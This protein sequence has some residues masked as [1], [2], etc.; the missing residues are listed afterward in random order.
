MPLLENEVDISVEFAPEEPLYRRALASELVDGELVVSSLESVSFGKEVSGAPS[1]L[2]GRFAKPIDAL[3]ADCAGGK[4]V[5]RHLV[6]FILVRDLPDVIQTPE[7]NAFEFYPL[8][9]PEPTCGAHSVIASCLAGDPT[10]VYAKPSRT[11]RNDLRAK[12]AVRLQRVVDM[13]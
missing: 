4:D 12:L 3:H 13:I 11:V 8:H 9:K 1:V 2:R 7:G 5:S 10:R 6:Y